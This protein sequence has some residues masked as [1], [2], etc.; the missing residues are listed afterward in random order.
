MSEVAMTTAPETDAE[1]PTTGL[2]ERTFT[3][4]DPVAIARAGAGLSGAEFFSAIAAG[5]IPPPPIMNA[6]DLEA[7]AFTDGRAVFRVT[8][9]EFHYNPLGTMHGGVFA[10]LLDSACGCAVHTTL[11]E[12]VFYTS[13]DLSVKFLRSVTVGT[14]PVT[15]EG[16][17]VHRGR[18]TALA[19]AKITDAAGKVYAT[20]TSSC[21]L[22]RPEQ[23]TP[24]HP[25]LG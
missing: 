7:V 22:L 6:L 12:G 13:L 18:R 17:V 14:G 25:E 21:L 8:P 10:A 23:P 3:W 11:P 1:Q 15:A 5:K 24:P 20:A 4:D 16:T 2:R 19:E 9:Q